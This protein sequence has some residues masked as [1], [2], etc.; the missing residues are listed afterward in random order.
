[1]QHDKGNE[2]WS[3]EI[4]GS[5]GACVGSGWR[6][7]VAVVAVVVVAV[8]VA[9]VVEVLLLLFLFL[10]LFLFLL[11]VVVVVEVA[12]AV[13]VVAFVVIV[14]G[15]GHMVRQ[16]AKPIISTGESKQQTHRWLLRLEIDSGLPLVAK[17]EK[18][19][20]CVRELAVNVLLDG[21]LACRLDP[22]A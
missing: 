10:F 8:A 3:V 22:S 5:N 2:H 7:A 9:L 4:G 16:T 6:F 11:F 14:V 15:V 13:V 12:A 18:G 21:H 20:T 19:D 17:H 1:M